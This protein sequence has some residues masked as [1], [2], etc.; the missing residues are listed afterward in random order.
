MWS[1]PSFMEVMQRGFVHLM[2]L[3]S[4]LGCSVF[5]LRH[6]ASR[7]KVMEILGRHRRY[8]KTHLADIALYLYYVLFSV[9]LAADVVSATLQFSFSFSSSIMW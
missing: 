1:Q 8:V 3:T 6:L 2:T 4:R 9:L 7:I 5:L